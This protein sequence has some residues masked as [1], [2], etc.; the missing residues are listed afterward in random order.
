MERHE[1]QSPPLLRGPVQ[2]SH[3][4]LGRF[5]YEGCRVVDA[6]CGNGHDTLVLA[7]LA[8]GTG[9][10]WAFDIQEAALTAT[11][12]KLEEAGLDQ[13]VRLVHAGHEQ[14]GLHVGEAVHAVVFNFGY[15]PG[16]DRG[17]VTSLDTSLRA[18]TIALGLLLPGGIVAAGVYPG[19]PGGADEGAAIEEWATTLPPTFHAWRM[20]RLNTR[21]AAPY[22]ILI[23]KVS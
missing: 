9:R 7:R 16:G 4:L 8:G 6:T 10:V 1:S 21:S 13:R 17:I 2:L 3:L 11:R 14:M 19:H 5:V 15:L 23:Q 22:F 20:G 12:L 18:L